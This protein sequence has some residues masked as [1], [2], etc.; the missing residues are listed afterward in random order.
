MLYTIYHKQKVIL[1]I[2]MHKIFNLNGLFYAKRVFD[3][4]G[5]NDEIQCNLKMVREKIFRR[6]KKNTND[7]QNILV[8]FHSLLYL[9]QTPILILEGS[10]VRRKY[11]DSS[12]AQYKQ[13]YLQV[14]IQYNKALKQRNAL[15][16]NFLKEVILMNNS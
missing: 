8:S 7:F 6:I 9:Q 10:E 12:I 4:E 1:I 3:K 2:L 14:L 16:N 11:L 13:S 15:L 5:V